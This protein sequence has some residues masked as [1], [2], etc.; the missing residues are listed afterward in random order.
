MK[1]TMTDIE[2]HL[3]K[4]G[5]EIYSHTQQ[6]QQQGGQ[7]AGGQEQSG[8]QQQQS[9]GKPGDDNIVDAEVVDDGK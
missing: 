8:G 6:N 4:F 3:M 7:Q 1:A 9:S 2:Q 5:Q